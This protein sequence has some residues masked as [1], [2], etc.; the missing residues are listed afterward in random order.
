MSMDSEWGERRRRTA[1]LVLS[2]LDGQVTTDEY[3][4]RLEVDTQSGDEE[5]NE[6]LDLVE[7]EPTRSRLLGLRAAEHAE[8]VAQ[9]RDR[10]ERLARGT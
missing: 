5:L 9:V 7:H 8:Y 1:A 2:L 3:W 4:R 6:L 10:A